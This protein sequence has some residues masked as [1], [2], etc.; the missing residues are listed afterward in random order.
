MDGREFTPIHKPPGG[1]A[2]PNMP[3]Y[4]AARADFDW[5][6]ARAALG[7]PG[8]NIA[9][10]AL[11]RAL[12]A[13]L[14]EH[15]A[16]RFIDRDGHREDYSYAE[17]ARAAHRCANALVGLG[18]ARSSRVFALL[19]R[20]PAL[21]IATLGTLAAGMVFCPLFSAFGPEPV[22]M[23]LE[24]GEG[25]VLITT[26]ALYARKVAP[27]RARLPALRHVLIVRDSSA[28]PADTLD[29]DALLAAASNE[30]TTV[31]TQD[32][33]IA[34]LHFTSGTT[35]RPKG[36]LHAHAAVV[37][38]HETARLAL[39]LKSDDRYWCTA[40]PG[41]V[42]GMTY[43]VL[44]PLTCGVSCIV[45]QEEFDPE[46]WYRLLAEEQVSVWYTAPTAIRMLM[47]AGTALARTRACPRLRFLASVG[48]PLNPEAVLWGIE[49]FGL[50]FHD[51]WWQTET[52]SIV[53]ANYPSVDVRPGSMGLPFPGIETAIVRRRED[54]GADVLG[55]SEV[56]EL[57][58]RTPWP[59]MMRGYLHEE[60]RYRA[61]FAGEWYLSG[62]LA[63]RDADGYYWFVGRSDDVIKSAGHLISP[64]EVES[65]L[66]AHA[67]VAQAG[68]I[69][70]PDALAG[71]V[72]K[73]FVELKPGY[74]ADTRLRQELLAHARRHLGAAVA[75]RDLAFVESLPR[76][77]SGKI[78][79]RVLRAREL[80]LP[81]GDVST[82]EGAAS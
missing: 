22:R 56:G 62:D 40:D 27:I 34:L 49:A 60:A 78:L 41:W 54:G 64:F 13:G 81:E 8:L 80:G 50:P 73:A 1:A 14:G 42:T 70:L 25:A 31:A 35:G 67:A 52:G 75:P 74:A 19:P 66:L 4:E 5:H 58:V 7:G 2:P 33:D 68:V 20:C 18:L 36:V 44:A 30:F 48:E 37:A 39:D 55:P 59:S 51:N 71:A 10:V 3:S 26:A 29:F 46:R 28:L 45:D 23:R 11:D 69:G 17:L 79:R 6:A 32:E 72:V 38:H 9:G 47:K 82:L 63:R 65:V 77:R 16:V 76:T 24:L 43:G 61:C 21:H 57:A 15:L 12:A 53:V